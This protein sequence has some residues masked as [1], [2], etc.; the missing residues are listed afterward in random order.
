MQTNY[1]PAR[2]AAFGFSYAGSLPQFGENVCE[3]A[4]FKKVP[5]MFLGFST[6]VFGFG[7]E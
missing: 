6:H 1:A 2:G 7:A 5:L 3:M 4:R